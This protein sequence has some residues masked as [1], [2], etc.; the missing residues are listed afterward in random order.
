MKNILSIILLLFC[1]PLVAQVDLENGL[2]TYFSFDGN[3][4]DGSSL[5]N[6][7][8]PMEGASLTTDMNETSASAIIFDGI[9]DYLRIPNQ[10]AF[11]FEQQ[12]A[13]TISFWIQVADEQPNLSGTVND[14]VSKWN[15]TSTQPYSYT[16][17][18]FNQGSENNGRVNF[19]ISQSTVSD[20]EEPNSSGLNSVSSIND[21]EWHHLLFSRTDDNMLRI[22]IDC[23]LENEIE[24]VINC[25]LSNMEDLFLGLRVPGG[26]FVRPFA[27]KLDEFRIYNRALNKEELGILCG[28]IVN[29]NEV[30]STAISFN[31]YPNP[32]KKGQNLQVLS[33]NIHQLE[34]LKIYTINGQYVNEYSD[35]GQVYLPVGTYIV[36]ARFKDGQQLIKKLIITD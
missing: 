13:F 31:L 1:L 8:Q 26:P 17:R 14:I 5:N 30:S 18:Y 21:G 11:S 35:A 2:V 16:I 34:S 15:N 27:G 3:F 36:K 29:V 23:E 4:E 28:A 32:A 22:Y 12:T 20:C 24:D 9:D 33:N 10:E 25:S 19:G 6:D 7:A